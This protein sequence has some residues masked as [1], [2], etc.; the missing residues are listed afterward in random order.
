[1][2]VEATIMFF[3]HQER[4]LMLQAY[5]NSNTCFA[6]ADRSGTKSTHVKML[7]DRPSNAWKPL[8]LK[9]LLLTC[10]C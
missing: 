3:L 9:P 7:L 4:T 6:L 2:Q 1:M 10:T 8:L 5:S